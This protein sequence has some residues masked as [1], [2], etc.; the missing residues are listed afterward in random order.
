MNFVT[1]GN[2]KSTEAFG[3][4]CSRLGATKSA[5]VSLE[6]FVH[7]VSPGNC[8]EPDQSR[9]PVTMEEPGG[10]D[11]EGEAQEAMR[12]AVVPL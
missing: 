10:S 5:R 3:K 9:T 4:H 6:R 2:G 1:L 12:G 8:A 7:N 11:W